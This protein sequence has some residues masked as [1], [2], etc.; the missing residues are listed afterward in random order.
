MPRFG[1]CVMGLRVKLSI[2]SIVPCRFVTRG[3]VALVMKQFTEEMCRREGIWMAILTGFKDN[4]GEVF[5]NYQ[6]WPSISWT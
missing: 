5:S 2:Q 3:G 4:K 1:T 6:K